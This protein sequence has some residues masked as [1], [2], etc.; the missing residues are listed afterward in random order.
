MSTVIFIHNIHILSNTYFP[1]FQRGVATPVIPLPGSATEPHTVEE[2][3][4]GYIKHFGP[5]KYKQYR[6]LYWWILSCSHHQLSCTALILL[7]T[8]Q[9]LQSLY[10][11][12]NKVIYLKNIK[13][14]TI[15]IRSSAMGFEFHVNHLPK[16]HAGGLSLFII[17]LKVIFSVAKAFI[18]F[19]ILLS[20]SF[21]I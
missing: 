11:L 12:A 8:T 7:F 2:E 6:H 5:S 17:Y 20:L 9:R 19:E 15:R 21:D 13:I 4:R 18:G 3:G 14:R 16:N 1:I 10:K